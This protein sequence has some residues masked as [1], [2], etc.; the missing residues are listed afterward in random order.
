MEDEEAVRQDQERLAALLQAPKEASVCTEH[1]KPL[2]EAMSVDKIAEIKAKRM[3]KKKTTIK[4]DIEGPGAALTARRFVDA[5]VEATRKI[6]S[7]ER[8]GRT[9]TTILQS[10]GKTFRDSIFAILDSVKAREAGQ[11]P[12][13]PAA[14]KAAAARPPAAYDRYDQERFR[15]KKDTGD[16]HIDT[17]GTY[18]GLSLPSIQPLSAFLS[19]RLSLRLRLQEARLCQ[20][21][22]SKPGLP[23]SRAT[24]ALAHPSSSFR[25]PPPL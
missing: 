4:V 13:Q 8:L 3:T 20:D 25:R 19:L 16:F 24:E 7:R 17:T 15:H 23:R 14:P 5:D 11:A 21:P 2:S 9:R 22:L 10:T 6:V 12:E 18:H 1:L